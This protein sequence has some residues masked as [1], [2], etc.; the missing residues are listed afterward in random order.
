MRKFITTAALIACMP[1]MALAEEPAQPNADAAQ[2]EQVTIG[3][4][5]SENG[6]S[7]QQAIQAAM[8]AD[9]TLSR[10]PAGAGTQTSGSTT[11]RSSTC[12][13]RCPARSPRAGC[14]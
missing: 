13:P 10:R 4:M 1:M 7:A 12:S 2:S 14:P 11:V 6:L 9:P 3:Q 5:M 8:S